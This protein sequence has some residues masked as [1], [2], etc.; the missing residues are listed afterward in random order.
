MIVEGAGMRHLFVL[1][2]LFGFCAPSVE[3][4]ALVRM[5]PDQEKYF[6][7]EVI[8]DF[9]DEHNAEIEVVHY[10]SVDSIDRELRLTRGEAGLVKVPFDR[11]ASLTE[12]GLIRSLDSF[13]S[14]SELSEFR[15]T[16]LLTSLG[17]FGGKQYYVP[18]KFE[19]RILVYRISKVAEAVTL[20]KDHRADIENELR[21]YNQRGLP[22]TYRLESDPN[23]WDFFDVFVVGWVWA[24]TPQDGRVSPRVAHRGKEYSGTA[25]RVIDRVYQCGGNGE[26]IV[27]INGEAVTDAFFWEAIYAASGIYNPRM[28]EEQWS[29]TGVWEGF[30]SDDVYLSFM[31]QLDCFF[32]HGTGRDG[33]SG[34]LS[35]PDDMGVAI[36]PAGCS[37]DLDSHGNIIRNGAS[38]VSTGGWW[39]G[40]PADSPDPR[41]SY[42]LARH[43]TSTKN[44]IQGCGRFGM[45][46]V[47]KDV[48]SDMSML[49]GG[50]WISNIY[51]V[52][53]E[54][55]MENRKTVL[56]SQ[57][58]F[59]EVR[60]VYLSAWFDIVV[61]G[62]WSA[63][64]K[65][66]NR[67][68][69]EDL[70]SAVYSPKVKALATE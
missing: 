19:T 31:T 2:L 39:W 70:L 17:Q 28:W 48:L 8:P 40:I 20:W 30:G 66:P 21:R 25:L 61:R 69:I 4:K 16:Y 10:E 7:S 57:S 32:I 58:G 36:M 27:E 9:E 45:I 56:P 52:S 29:G 51:A 44:Q 38:A 34:Y 63:D 24:H 15:D 53:F 1:F 22:A 68:Y 41:A 60:D 47:R 46:P 5:I 42:K 50:G 64:R 23:E 49:F 54:Q 33:L 62:N 3:M 59:D 13:L 26:E 67:Q 14:E 11:A 55:L 18:R 43:I 65:Y 6:A 12:T 35:D 37:V